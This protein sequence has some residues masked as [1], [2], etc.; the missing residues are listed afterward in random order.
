[1]GWAISEL[2]MSG[3]GDGNH[4]MGREG[5]RCQVRANNN[6]LL[7]GCDDKKEVKS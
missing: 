6:K 5:G 2:K 4:T 3:L 1:M 7:D